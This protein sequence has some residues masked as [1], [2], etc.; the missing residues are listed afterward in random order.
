[1]DIY[2]LYQDEEQSSAFAERF[3]GNIINY[4]KFCISC[5]VDLCDECRV[6][7]GSKA[8]NILGMYEFPSDL[9]DMIEEADE[10]FPTGVPKVDVLVVIGI[11][12]DLLSEIPSFME[13][14]GINTVIIPIENGD[15][16]PLGLQK[17]LERDLDEKGF[18]YAFPRPFCS[19]TY[20]KF[21]KVNEF[22]NYFKIGRPVIELK[23]IDGKIVKGNVITNTPCGCAFYMVRQLITKAD[24]DSETLEEKISK[25]HHSYPCNAS[26]K[27]DPVLKE[28]TLHVGG[29]IHRFCVYRALGRELTEEEKAI[30]DWEYEPKLNHDNNTVST[31]TE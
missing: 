19:L 10:Y 27:H 15:W 13:K 25:A 6:D 3:M 16:C 2:V 24:D 7:Y 11:H 18:Q 28:Q 14:N 4:N 21:D 12:Q 23:T 31:T 29:Y 22:I 30:E 1:M 9:P 8:E 20:N 5:G 26:M 17:Q